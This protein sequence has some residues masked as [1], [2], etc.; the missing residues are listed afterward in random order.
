MFGISHSCSSSCCRS[1]KATNPVAASESLDPPAPATP[2]LR[3]RSAPGVFDGAGVRRPR[4]KHP[5]AQLGRPGEPFLRSSGLSRPG[6]N[7]GNGTHMKT[8]MEAILGPTRVGSWTPLGGCPVCV[9]HLGW[10]GAHL[11]LLA[12]CVVIDLP[13]VKMSACSS[14]RN[15]PSL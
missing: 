15:Q 14:N 6:L 4:A 9:E 13:S 10:C 11:W 8:I 2:W 1:S 3:S 5:I 7:M 12:A